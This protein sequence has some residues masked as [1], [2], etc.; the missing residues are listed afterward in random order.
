MENNKNNNYKQN[1]LNGGI[2]AATGYEPYIIIQD[3]PPVYDTSGKDIYG[4]TGLIDSLKSSDHESNN[5][6]GVTMQHFVTGD[7]KV[8]TYLEITGDRDIQSKSNKMSAFGRKLLGILGIS[9]KTKITDNTANTKKLL[10]QNLKL[11]RTIQDLG[12]YVEE[13]EAQL[14]ESK[15]AESARLRNEDTNT[16]DHHIRGFRG[17]KLSNKAIRRLNGMGYDI[18]GILD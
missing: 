17:L 13:L 3:Y 5:D 16:V 2:N 10:D 1:Q 7:G 18:D 8:G 15:S 11:S 12:R 6:N 9:S 4:I 14:A